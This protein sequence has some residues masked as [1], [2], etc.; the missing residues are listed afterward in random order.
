MDGTGRAARALFPEVPDFTDSSWQAGRSDTQL[1]VSVLHGKGSTMPGW[2]GK[3]NREQARQL[4]G[5]VRT[6]SAAKRSPDKTSPTSFEE[7]FHHLQKEFDDLRRAL[8]SLSERPIQPATNH[9]ARSL[10][11]EPQ[12]QPA[13]DV[14]AARQLFIK[15]CGKCHEA[16]GKGGPARKLFPEMPDFTDASWQARRSDAQLLA[17]ILEGKGMGMPGWSGKIG[18]KE[19]REFVALIRMFAPRDKTPQ[20][21]KDTTDENTK[22]RNDRL[23]G[24]P[25][26]RSGA[27]GPL[28]AKPG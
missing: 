13:A 2:E 16:N 5:Y 15:H 28:W 7:S 11:V 14:P 8:K 4:A 21:K 18:K 20:Q 27:I 9:Q 25:G 22:R 12:E 10:A 23:P 26:D 17:S 3:I 6:F 24:A 1:V 19:A